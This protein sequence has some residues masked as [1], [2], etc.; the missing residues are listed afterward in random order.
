MAHL[1]GLPIAV[2]LSYLLYHLVLR[3]A[4]FSPLSKLPLAHPSAGILS[5]WIWWQRRRGR[6]SRA[7]H[8]AH[9]QRGSIVRLAPNEVSVA[10]LDGLRTIYGSGS[11]FSRTNWFL[12]FRNYNG[13]PN[14]V[15][16]FSARQH[17]TRKR[18]LSHLYSK[19]YLFASSN[20]QRAAQVVV[21]ERLMPILDCAAQTGDGV[22]VYALG[23]AAPAELMSMYGMG[24]ANGLDLVPQGR[25]EERKRYLENGK[26]KLRNLKWAKMAAKELE[27]QLFELCEKAVDLLRQVSPGR[28]ER[29]DEGHKEM[30]NSE[31]HAHEDS[32]S[33][34]TYPVVFAQLYNSI[35][36]K[37]GVTDRLET[38]HLAASELLDSIEAGRE[39]IGISLTYAMHQLS[40]RPALQLTL[41]D[42]LMK[43]TPP[44]TYP[45]SQEALSTSTL[46]QLDSLALLDGIVMET[47]RVHAPEPGPQ[48]RLVPEGGAVVEG[49]FIPA[50][51]TIHSSPYCL[52][53]YEG[54][55]P[56]A[57][58]WRPER[59]MEIRG[60]KDSGEWGKGKAEDDPRRWFWA[61]GSGGK[62]CI[63]SNFSLLGKFLPG[64]L[65][66]RFALIY[67]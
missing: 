38:L 34:T 6:E 15:T 55:Y 65:L 44:L 12:P 18:M 4:L 22:D 7:I 39:G 9:Q 52:H 27:D 13:R 26:R 61:F 28:E 33:P 43:L 67:G 24:T 31:N 11:D 10:S 53:R 29:E 35:P 2:L 58:V 42:E 17:A 36:T 25:E 57:N 23:R 46:R 66:P 45:P 41:H 32:E 20:F 64:I 59:W 48:R 8:A 14:L 63:G 30:G 19:S 1:I 5:T 40:Q 37:E 60:N 16:M 49:Y 51:V 3:P 62:M 56:D 47:L 21:F 50:G 54:V